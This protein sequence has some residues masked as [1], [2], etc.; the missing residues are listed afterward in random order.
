[1]DRK[2][3]II[4]NNGFLGRHLETHLKQEGWEV[5]GL[6]RGS[7]GWD[8]KTRGPWESVLSGATA[9]INY[10]GAP[11]TLPW[12]PTNRDLILSSRVDTTGI[13][14]QAL[15]NLPNP[16]VW[17]NASAVGIY[18]DRADEVLDETSAGGTG[19]LADVCR[20]WEAALMDP[21]FRAIPRVALR[22]GIVLGPDGGALAP[23]A[24]LA[25]IGL[26]G[27]L[28]HGRQWMPWIHVHDP[29]RMVEYIISSGL[30]GEINA[31][32]PNPATNHDFAKELRK[33]VNCPI[34]IPTPRI[35]LKVASKLGG[36]DPS[37]LLNSNRVMPTRARNAGFVFEFSDLPA[38]LA[39]CLRRKR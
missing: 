20:A 37:V 18:G 2:A 17:I 38:A 4:G 36:P 13:I 6:R 9:V 27:D 30:T 25:K 11:V 24:K 10:S 3:L 19:F 33:A 23:L 35:A 31:V 39:D 12:T 26:G 29:A 32:G 16:P 21:A 28:G 5:A 22:T 8:G 7:G 34:G 1:M 14:G 15:L